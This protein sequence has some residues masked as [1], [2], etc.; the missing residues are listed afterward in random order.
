MVN[1]SLLVVL[2][3]IG[4]LLEVII[5]DNAVILHAGATCSRQGT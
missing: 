3:S 5:T 4:I 2:A 1:A